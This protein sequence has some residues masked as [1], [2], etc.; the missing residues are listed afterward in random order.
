[1]FPNELYWR[2]FDDCAGFVVSDKDSCEI[3]YE[4]LTLVMYTPEE[5]I[6]GEIR[7]CEQLVSYARLRVTN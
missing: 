4:E 2:Q 7:N 1:M 3:R 6:T 5:C